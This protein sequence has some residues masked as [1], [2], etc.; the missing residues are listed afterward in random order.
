MVFLGCT[1]IQSPTIIRN[2]YYTNKNDEDENGVLPW[3]WTV[4][5]FPGGTVIN[6]PPANVGGRRLKRLEFN[7]WVGKIPQRR[8]W[9]PTLAFLPEKS[10]GQDPG[11]LQFME[12]QRIRLD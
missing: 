5:G 2:L 6:N 12:S 4:L 1:V 3:L 7:S 8:K 10:H 11:R 9:Q